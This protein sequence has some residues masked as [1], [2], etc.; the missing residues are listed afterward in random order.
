VSGVL[1]EAGAPFWFNGQP[2]LILNPLV[3]LPQGGNRFDRD[4]LHNSGLPGEGPPQP[5]K[6]RFNRK[7]SF[8]YVCIVHPG[9]DGTV[10]VKG[11]RAR[12]PGARKDRRAARKEQQAAL[13]RAQRLTRGPGRLNKIVQAGNDDRRGTA[14]FKF[15]P[16]KP[17]FKVGD[18]VTMRMPRRSPEVHTVT[19]GP[20]NGENLY[21]DQIAA[22][23]ITP[24]LSGGGPP[25]I[26]LEPRAA[27][28]SDPPPAGPAP[29]SPT[30]H[31]N[32]YVNTG[33]LDSDPASP[34]PA[35][36]QVRFTAPGSYTYICLVHPFMRDTL[37]VTP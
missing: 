16:A 30:S 11:R 15:F 33:I 31:G 18:V 26:V 10:K 5:Y 22:A 19:F 34:V 8:D 13:R 32:G 3:A 37:T 20:S 4:T 14:I 35:S 1:D 21:V 27:Y 29:L 28:P 9:M 36:T 7:G 12:V 6:L 2:R 23:F 25:T 24:D 17:A